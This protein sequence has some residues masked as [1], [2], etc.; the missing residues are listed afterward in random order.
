MNITIK[1]QKKICKT[2]NPA[3]SHKDKTDYSSEIAVAGHSLAHVPHATHF[4]A[5]ISR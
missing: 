5:S 2:F 3:D 4:E 1:V